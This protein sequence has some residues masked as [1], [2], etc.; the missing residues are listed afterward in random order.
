[1]SKDPRI[2]KCSCQEKNIEN[3]SKTVSSSQNTSNL[4]TLPYPFY[5]TDS[6]YTPSYNSHYLQGNL[7]SYPRVGDSSNPM[8]YGSAGGEVRNYSHG[9]GFGPGSYH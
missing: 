6:Y 4:I 2:T 1:M 3:F 5:Y 7:V 8:N 9:R